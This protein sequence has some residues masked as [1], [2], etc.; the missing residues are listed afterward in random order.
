MATTADYA[1]VY[2]LWNKLQMCT[3]HKREHCIN[4]P[5]AKQYESSAC[6]ESRVEV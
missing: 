5:G 2:P 1:G 6:S 3:L 4:K